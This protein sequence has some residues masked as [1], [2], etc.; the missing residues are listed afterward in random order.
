[1]SEMA[2]PFDGTAISDMLA[3]LMASSHGAVLI[4]D[5][6][7]IGGALLPAYCAPSWVIAV[8]MFWWAESGGLRL[9]RAFEDWAREAGASEVRMTSLAAQPRAAEILSRRGY[10]AAEIS[11]SK[12]I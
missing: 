4:G 11:H 7:V 1:M 2:A 5:A 10:K 12:V 6:G 3:S 8:E 9:L